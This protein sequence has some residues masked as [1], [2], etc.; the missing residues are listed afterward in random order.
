[1]ADGLRELRADGWRLGIVTNGPPSQMDKITGTG[2]D[3]LVDG[4]AV[5][6]E[7]GVRKPD[8]RI[9]EVAAQRCGAALTT[10]SW[11]VGDSA[12]ADM[13]GARN[14]GLRSVWLP[15][16]KV[17]SDGPEPDHRVD[18]VT[19]AIALIASSPVL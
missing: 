16:G 15:R 9:F 3:R 5:S 1:M 14:A 11:M 4:W 17:W 6:D 18:D 2:L 10:T 12:P 13:V 19:Q 7:V 8:R